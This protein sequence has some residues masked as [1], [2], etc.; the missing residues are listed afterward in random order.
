MQLDH[1]DKQILNA[2]FYKGCERLT[3]IAEKVMKPDQEMMSHTGIRKRI[4]KL[5]QSEILKIQG[6]VNLHHLNYKACIILL[7]MKNYEEVKK[8][9]YAYSDCPRVFF[10]AEVTGQFN[11]I[12]GIVGQNIEVL[13]QYINYCGPTN[14]DG[15]LHS[16]ILFFSKFVIPE[17]LPL[18]LFSNQSQESKC[19]NCCK[20]CEAYLDGRCDGCGNF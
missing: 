8:V 6:N 20:A 5:E 17:F 10:L 1:I 15:I 18:N 7:E 16:D 4:K 11:L 19:G 12:I 2:L 3:R 13:H 9:K 14:K